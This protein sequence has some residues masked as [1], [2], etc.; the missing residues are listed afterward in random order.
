MEQFAMA[1]KVF[2]DQWKVTPK[3]VLGRTVY[4]INIFLN[5]FVWSHAMRRIYLTMIGSKTTPE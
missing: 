5:F 4:G 3:T 2:H 1:R